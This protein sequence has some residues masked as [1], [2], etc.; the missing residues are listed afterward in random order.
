MSKPAGS[1]AASRF[2]FTGETGL[3]GGAVAGGHAVAIC[4][5]FV[6]AIRHAHFCGQPSMTW[7]VLSLMQRTR[8]VMAAC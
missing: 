1:L 7:E 5:A 6:L 8:A 3:N 4:I 2:I